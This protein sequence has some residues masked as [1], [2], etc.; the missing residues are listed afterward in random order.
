MRRLLLLTICTLLLGTTVAQSIC[1]EGL[2]ELIV[3]IKTDSYGYE[4]SW[5]LESSTGTLYASVMPNSYA[6]QTLYRDTICLPLDTCVT[7][8]I[9]DEFGDG[10][11]ALGYY[12]LVL[13]G[14]TLKRGAAF[15][16]FESFSFQCAQGEIC[17]K[18]ILA[19][20]GERIAT[21]EDTWYVFTPGA[22]GIYRI[23]TCES[24]DCDTKI[25]IYDKCDGIT[26][27]EDN[28]STIFFNDDENPCAPQAEVKGYFQKNKKYYIRI[29]DKAN[30]CT[31]DIWWELV[32]EGPVRGCM[33]PMSC[34]YNPL[35]TIDDGSC[36][37]QGHSGCPAGPDLRVRQDSLRRSIRLDTVHAN[38]YCLIEEGCLRGYGVRQVMRFSTIIENIGERDYFIGKPSYDNPQFSYNNCHNHFHYDSYAEYLLF[39]EDG[40]EIP[41]GFKNGFCITD[42]GCPPG[43][44]PKFSCDN[45]GISAGCYDT[46]WSD[47]QC[48]WIDLTDVPDGRYTFVVRINWKNLPDALGQIEMDTTNNWAQVCLILDRSSGKLKVIADDN[49]QPYTDCMGMPYGNALL[50]CTGVCA[51]PALPGDVDENG[52]QTMNDAHRYVTLLLGHDIVPGTCFDLNADNKITVYDA[53]LLANCLNY[54]A[55]HQHAG[56]GAHNHCQFPAGLTNINDTVSLSI[57]DI[58]WDYQYVDIGIRNPDAEVNAYQ[59]E[60][61]GLYIAYVENLVTDGSFPIAP[62]TSMNDGIVVGISYQ[63]SMITKS[64]LFQP[65]CRVHFF[66]AYSDTI[67]IKSDVEIVNGNYERTI[68]RLEEACVYWQTTSTAAVHQLKNV[69]VAPNPFQDETVISFYNPDHQAFQMKLMDVNGKIVQHFSDVKDDEIHVQSKDLASGIYFFRLWNERGYATGKL[70]LQ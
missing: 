6:N 41:L 35:A 66:K 13:D 31:S 33:D 51:G 62:R 32:F 44:T 25:W 46:Y 20:P 39:R 34:N 45:M 67:C 64:E 43:V 18:A 52:T 48:Q 47:L 42:F 49:C 16:E 2:S 61:Q 7:F 59:F 58:N 27:A 26:V 70:I 11:G 5:K 69:R 56:Y 24:N 22:T 15:R 50:D 21:L 28:Q 30:A 9:F 12:M 23:S 17:S 37:P 53:A 55:A 57:L 4:T 60:L 65:L 36:L 19:T 14:D 3:E 40:S 29:G 8:T 10:M 54:G 68:A 38:D 63:D 1:A